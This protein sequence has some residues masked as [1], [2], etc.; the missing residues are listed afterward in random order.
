MR[1]A[2]GSAAWAL[3]H[4]KGVKLRSAAR[5]TAAITCAIFA[6]WGAQAKDNG[7]NGVVAGSARTSHDA[8]RLPTSRILQRAGERAVPGVW[9]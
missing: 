4:L 2:A 1:G 7:W 9:L 5:Q 8:Q 6:E 3:L